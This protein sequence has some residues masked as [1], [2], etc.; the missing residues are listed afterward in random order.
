MIL[1]TLNIESNFYLFNAIQQMPQ[2]CI[3]AL[4]NPNHSTEQSNKLFPE[5]N[6][7]SIKRQKKNIEQALILHNS[8]LVSKN[9]RP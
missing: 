6:P 9:G 1:V 7:S 4:K 3:A 2:I 8:V 5:A